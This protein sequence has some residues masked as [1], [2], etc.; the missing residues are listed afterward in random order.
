MLLTDQVYFDRYV[1]DDT[2]TSYLSVP[3]SD[4]LD[5]GTGDFTFEC[6]LLAVK[7]SGTFG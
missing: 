6:W 1:A 7:H 5:M 3:D 2:P 4:D